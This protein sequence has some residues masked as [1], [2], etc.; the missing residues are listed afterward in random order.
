MDDQEKR[1]RNRAQYPGA[2]ELI[3]AH[4]AAFGDDFVV[5]GML[6]YPTRSRITKRGHEPLKFPDEED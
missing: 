1:E 2:T 3:D 4:R 5:T 6:D